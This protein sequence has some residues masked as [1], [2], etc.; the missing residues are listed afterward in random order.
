M[1][2]RGEREV[3][4]VVLCLWR[5]DGEWSLQG[6]GGVI[7]VY[8]FGFLGTITARNV[9]GAQAA[10]A[11]AIEELTGRTVIGWEPDVSSRSIHGESSWYPHTETP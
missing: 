4:E 10:A 3:G 8:G 7:E 9:R 11:A 2:G 5:E 6:P 1:A